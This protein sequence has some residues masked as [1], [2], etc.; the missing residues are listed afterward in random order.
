MSQDKL[1]KWMKDL[2]NGP[3]GEFENKYEERENRK[4]EMIDEFKKAKDFHL[5][6]ATLISTVTFIV[7]FTLPGVT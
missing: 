1:L 2:G 7:T 4:L 3:L 5:V 6:V